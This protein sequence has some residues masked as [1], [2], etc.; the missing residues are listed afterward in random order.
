M[1]A[2]D[3]C[4]LVKISPAALSMAE[5]LGAFQPQM[6]DEVSAYSLTNIQTK[7]L[8]QWFWCQVRG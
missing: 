4:G 2:N 7:V 3:K 1:T 8:S 5:L 6:Q